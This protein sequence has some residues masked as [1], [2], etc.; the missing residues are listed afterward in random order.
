VLILVC[1]NDDCGTV[2]ECERYSYRHKKL[3]FVNVNV[4]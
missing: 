4:F 3:H 1:D 2:H